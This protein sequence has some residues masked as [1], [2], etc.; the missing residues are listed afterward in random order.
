ML[1]KSLLFLFVMFTAL[2]FVLP[3]A[4]FQSKVDGID[5]K[6]VNLSA[7]SQLPSWVKKGALAKTNRGLAK[8]VSVDGQTFSV[9]VKKSTAAKLKS[10]DQLE[11]TPKNAGKG[12]K[13]QGC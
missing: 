8:V 5:G 4:A 11:V 9:K 6:V 2:I 12:N 7:D 1:K 10:G 13:L 3:V